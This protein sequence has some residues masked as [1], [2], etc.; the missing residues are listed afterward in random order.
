MVE[1]KGSNGA[2]YEAFLKDVTT[3]SIIV[4]FDKNW[5]PEKKIPFTE[6]RLA[7]QGDILTLNPEELV[8]GMHVEVS[9]RANDREPHGW[10]A[11]TVMMV[12][13][14]KYAISYHLSPTR[15]P[16]CEVVPISRL[17]KVNRQPSLDLSPI[18][19]TCLKVPDELCDYCSKHSDAHQD[20]KRS[21]RALFSTYK[22]DTQMLEV[23]M[24]DKAIQKRVEIVA[25]MH[26]RSL[27]TKV[28]MLQRVEEA[29]E[30][31]KV[32]EERATSSCERFEVS[33]ELI[34]LSIGRD[35]GNIIAARSIP[36][37]LD[38]MLDEQ[39]HVFTVYGDSDIA[40]KKAREL[41]EYKEQEYLVPQNFVGKV[42]GK[43]GV[44]IQEMID[45][46]GV[47]KVRVVGE[48][49]NKQQK[50]P[51]MVPFRFIGTSESIQNVFALLDYHISYLKD[52]ELLRV[53]RYHLNQKIKQ[54]S[55]SRPSSGYVSSSGIPSSGYISPSAATNGVDDSNGRDNSLGD[56][57]SRGKEQRS[58]RAGRR[59]RGRGRGR[60]NN[61]DRE[62]APS[63][64]SNISD[65]NS[66]T[67]DQLSKLRRGAPDNRRGG[68]RG[69]N[70][71]RG[72]FNDRQ[73]V[74]S[75]RQ[76]NERSTNQRGGNRGG[77]HKPPSSDPNHNRYEV[78]ASDAS[79]SGVDVEL[80]LNGNS[81]RGNARSNKNSR[82]SRGRGPKPRKT[83]G[84]DQKMLNG[85]IKEKQPAIKSTT[86]TSKPVDKP[87]ATTKS[88]ET[89]PTSVEAIVTNGTA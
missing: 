13:P 23:F 86:P 24:L 53:Q 31:L 48:E 41:L 45:K 33:A 5:Q 80:N 55:V 4:T 76:G 87:K 50:Q 32:S 42:I 38:I 29:T 11:A 15:L 27:R 2:F 69:R 8:E 19:K 62:S 65:T 22:P 6:A 85:D 36:G 26:F 20:F 51:D 54:L 89:K 10:F 82:S 30:Q 25:D 84:G 88:K 49:E 81:T 35:G 1:V 59:G 64:L 46:S 34:G 52:L 12:N 63:E 9:S 78:L 21:V 71:G 61:T 40:V 75:G 37:V 14:G 28:A 58:S 66:E 68:F 16:G 43:K 57:P 47:M 17:R 44:I 3:D 70:R 77:F 60:N 79:E 56:R 73:N 83:G 67:E 18:F 74:P 39:T 72:R 7:S